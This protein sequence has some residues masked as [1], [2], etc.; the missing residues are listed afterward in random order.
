M[1]NRKNADMK[2]DIWHKVTGRKKNRATEEI[3][4]QE[5]GIIQKKNKIEK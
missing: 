3:R 5:R 4:L 1:K 2:T